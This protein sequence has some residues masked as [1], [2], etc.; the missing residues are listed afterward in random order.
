M[1]LKDEKNNELEVLEEE[2][3]DE[4]EDIFEE[5]ESTQ[6]KWS[7]ST[8][9]II[10]ESLILLILSGIIV[11][12]HHWKNNPLRIAKEYVQGE[13]TGEWNDIYKL[14]AFEEEGNPFLSK[15]MFVTALGL[16][17]DNNNIIRAK[18]NGA[19]EKSPAGSERKTIEVS[20]I[21]NEEA[22]VKS[23]PMIRKKG[24]WFIDGD[25]EYVKKKMQIEVTEDAKVLFDGIVLDESFKK[26]TS[27]NRDLYELPKVFDGLHYV[28]LQKDNM[29][30]AEFMVRYDAEKPESLFMR[31]N[32]KVLQ[33][34][35][36][37]APKDIA[38]GYQ[39]AA[40][41][42]RAEEALLS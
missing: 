20:Y 23:V 15:K 34:A 35:G 8:K 37:Q 2:L 31:Y 9:I 28:V 19:K 22:L 29:E 40:K 7:R 11:G 36:E 32:E 30:K 27:D 38:S 17:F 41:K 4:D 6:K 25:K 24:Q 33:K 10:A 21:R 5:L 18:I 13:V 12:V 14:L 3:L 1:D 39:K 42:V 26:T 16:D